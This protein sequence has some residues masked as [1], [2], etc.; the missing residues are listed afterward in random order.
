MNKI[1]KLYNSGNK[2]VQA[3]IAD[4]ALTV[5]SKKSESFNKPHNL[6]YYGAPGTGKSHVLNKIA[7]NIGV[8]DADIKFDLYSRVTFYSDYSYGQFVGMYKPVQTNGEIKFIFKKD[9]LDILNSSISPDEKAWALQKK[10]YGNY[11][12]TLNDSELISKQKEY[13]KTQKEMDSMYSALAIMSI[14]HKI[15]FPLKY[16]DAFVEYYIQETKDTSADIFKDNYKGRLFDN[17]YSLY[18]KFFDKI[19]DY[20]DTDY[21]ESKD[22]DISYKF[23][24]GPF[25]KILVD[26]LNNPDKNYLLIIEEINRADA[27]AVFGDMFQL[28]D[29]N[30]DGESEYSIESHG[31]LKKYLDKKVTNWEG[32]N[33]SVLKIPNNMYIYATM[34]S[35]DQNVYPLDTAFKRRWSFEYIDIKNSDNV[36]EPWKTWVD[37]I[38]SELLENDVEEDKQIGYQFLSNNIISNNASPIELTTDSAFCREFKNKVIMY[39]FEDAGRFI[40]DELFGGRTSLSKLFTRYDKWIK[41]HA[42]DHEKLN[43]LEVLNSDPKTDTEEVNNEKSE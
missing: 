28:L 40:R 1:D 42:T 16:G 31:E 4:N 39:L 6:I 24:P 18:Y 33:N 29:R 10:F 23:I 15:E 2:T 38:N 43:I 34:N 19:T 8:D 35:A 36:Q 17:D 3:N 14:H 7:N 25:T 5:D 37:E 26:A 22:T 13:R 30:K 41:K 27:A 32:K 20:F 21:L 12:E 11:N 9:I